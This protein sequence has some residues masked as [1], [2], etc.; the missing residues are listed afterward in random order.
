MNLKGFKN[1][2]LAGGLAAMIL[3]FQ[4]PE[5]GGWQSRYVAVSESGALTYTPDA[6]GNIIPDFSRVGYH[7]GDK[8]IPRVPVIKVIRPAP[9][10]SSQDLIQKAIEEVAAR[11]PDKN[12]FRGAILLKK[13]SYLIPG[14]IRISTGGIVLRGEGQGA[15]G[16]RLVATG[17]GQRSLI[18][19]A[20]TGAPAELPGSRQ[21]ITDARVPT[22]AFSFQLASTAGFK[23]GDK[24]MVLRPGTQA[25]ITDLKM[26]QI[27]AREG[28]RQW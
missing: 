19:V 14:T 28:T 24:I 16:T 5:K 26:D 2:I 9:A 10:G 11:K 23:A 7:C 3:G 15:G 21:P 8:K 27:V 12:G 4:L 25:W 13:G 17:K 6:Q 18:V 1:I 22:G 20:G